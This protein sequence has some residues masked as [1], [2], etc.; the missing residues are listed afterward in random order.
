MKRWVTLI[1]LLLF[2]SLPIVIE[3]NQSSLIREMS[4]NEAGFYNVYVF[5]NVEDATEVSLAYSKLRA[6]NTEEVRQALKIS[7]LSYIHLEKNSLDDKYASSLT[8]GET[9]TFLV[10][11]HR[12][13][14]LETTVAEDVPAF[15]RRQTVS[16][17]LTADAGYPL[18]LW[19]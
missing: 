16:G 17:Q 18:R 14:V 12:S 2:V 4:A 1:L 9:P 6:I 7:R 15:L 10:L 11:D 13:V 19:R 8:I 3:R 5:W